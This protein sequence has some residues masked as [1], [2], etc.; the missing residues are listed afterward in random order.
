MGEAWSTRPAPEPTSSEPSYRRGTPEALTLQL[1]PDGVKRFVQ[2][3]LDGATAKD[4]ASKHGFGQTATK[5][6]LKRHGARKR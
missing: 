4:L 5:R 2:D 1:G 6:L 3:Y